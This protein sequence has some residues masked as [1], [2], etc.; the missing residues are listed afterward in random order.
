[1]MVSSIDNSDNETDDTVNPMYWNDG[2][3]VHIIESVY[4]SGFEGEEGTALFGCG[5]NRNCEILKRKGKN[6][7]IWRLE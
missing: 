3:S 4:N 1:M 2:S 7:S 6:W 5:K